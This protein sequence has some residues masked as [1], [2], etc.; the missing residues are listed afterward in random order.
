VAGDGLDAADGRSVLVSEFL[1]YQLGVVDEAAA[2][3]AVGRTLRVEFR[4][5]G[6]AE[7]ELLLALLNPGGRAETVDEE[8]ALRKA[9]ARLPEAV[10]A[11]KLS[12]DEAAALQG[13]IRRIPGGL[14]PPRTKDVVEEYAVRG[15]LRCCR[16]D[17]LDSFWGWQRAQTDLLLTPSAA[18]DLLDRLPLYHETGYASVVVEADDMDHVKE[19][20]LA[21]RGQ[22]YYTDALLEHAE[23]ERF[24]YLLIFAGMTLVAVMALVVA[25]LGISNTMLIGV[26]ERTREIGVM[27]AVGARDG[28]IQLMF[29]VEG[30]MVGLVGG[31]L[32]LVL[33]WAA[34][35]PADAW[36]RWVLDQNTPIK[37]EDSVFAFPWWLACG[38][39]AFACLATTLAA[40]YPARRAARV[41]PVEA[42]RHE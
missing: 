3:A 32:G 8:D 11:L 26:L 29:L 36:V 9:A 7:P 30:A 38:A 18:E 2:A 35:H 42:L 5:G 1:L 41:N 16:K 21:L 10:A 25:A 15:V 31:L 20:S 12:P 6:D 17:E 37:L 34:S 14:P 28:H 39:P 22:G 4:N 13:V 33:A 24:I 19:V 27:K 40:V 23:V